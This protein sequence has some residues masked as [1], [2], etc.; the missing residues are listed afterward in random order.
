MGRK[1][2]LAPIS[3]AEKIRIDLIE[4]EAEDIRRASNP[5]FDVDINKVFSPFDKIRKMSNLLDFSV[6]NLIDI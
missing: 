6:D 4:N 2:R 1:H 3:E 5:R